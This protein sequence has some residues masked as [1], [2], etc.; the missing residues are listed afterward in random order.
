MVLLM[1]KASP[2]RVR[3]ALVGIFSALTLAFLMSTGNAQPPFPGGPG[4][5][6][7]LPGLPGGA[8]HG[9]P[10]GPPGGFTKPPPSPGAS[11]RPPKTSTGSGLFSWKC[12][13]CG[14][15]LG[16]GP[17]SGSGF[18]WCPRCNA[19]LTG[20]KSTSGSGFGPNL[21]V[22]PAKTGSPDAKAPTNPASGENPT[23]A[24]STPVPDNAE[25]TEL[26]NPAPTIPSETSTPDNSSSSSSSGGRSK[27]LKLVGIV[28]GLIMLLGA[29][30]VLA[31]V[32][33]NASAASKPVKR[34][35]RRAFDDD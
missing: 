34:N 16:I 19:R 2:F 29:L 8:I 22:T 9:N 20:P 24:I 3:F 4:G 25:P 13:G 27:T 12:G 7:G 14:A 26:A 17:A 23:F 5:P 35:R 10:G 33:A 31:L 28:F 15:S 1:L 11:S 30:A 32:V 21:P 18:G 6:G